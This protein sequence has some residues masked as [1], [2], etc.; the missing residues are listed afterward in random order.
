MT[1]NP[2]DLVSVEDTRAHLSVDDD[3]PESLLSIYARGALAYCL[4]FCDRDDFD[5]VEKLPDDFRIGYLLVLADQWEH[6]S[7]QSEVQ[8]YANPAA[9]AFLHPLRD[10]SDRYR[11]DQEA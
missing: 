8:L 11:T 3:V 4:R 7:A 2:F 9:Q 10:L 1:L 5:A 6:R